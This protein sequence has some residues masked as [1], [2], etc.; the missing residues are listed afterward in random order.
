MKSNKPPI[1]IDDTSSARGDQQAVANYGPLDYAA[2]GTSITGLQREATTYVDHLLDS[3]SQ[4]LQNEYQ[5][6]FARRHI[7]ESDLWPTRQN[8]WAGFRTSGGE[9]N[10][11]APTNSLLPSDFRGG[12][13]IPDGF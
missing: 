4:R 13:N 12:I 6:E 1:E 3:F 10:G 7:S 8:T 9:T 2:H 11:G 5:E